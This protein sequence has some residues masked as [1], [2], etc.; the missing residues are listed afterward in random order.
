MS[1]AHCDAEAGYWWQ[2]V[3]QPVN[4]HSAIETVVK[5][6]F[7]H[8]HFLEIAAIPHLSRHIEFIVKEKN[9]DV[10]YLRCTRSLLAFPPLTSNDPSE[11]QREFPE[12]QEPGCIKEHRGTARLVPH[13]GCFH[14]AG[15][16]ESCSNHRV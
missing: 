9:P 10:Q 14:V 16:K 4:F 15:F 13:S 7:Q 3:R 1:E 6:N 5:M 12:S 11:F 2:N 8:M